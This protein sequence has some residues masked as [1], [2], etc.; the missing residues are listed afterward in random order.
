MQLPGPVY[1][2]P[3]TGLLSSPLTLQSP[4]FS[5]VAAALELLLELLLPGAAQ[6]LLCALPPV[7]ARDGSLFGALDPP[8]PHG[9]RGR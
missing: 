1:A 4:Q 2:A 6:L 8:R 9:T 5:A 3:D 7:Q